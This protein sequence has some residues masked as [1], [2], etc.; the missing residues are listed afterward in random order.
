MEKV[1]KKEVTF[2]TSDSD[3]YVIETI[4][5][6]ISDEKMEEIKKSMQICKD[7][8]FIENVR[9]CFDNFDFFDSEENDVTD[10]WRV[11]VSQLIVYKDGIYFYAQNKYDASDQLESEEILLSDLEN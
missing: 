5:L 4:Q 8:Q 6:T 10:V 1:I 11:D 3:N 2:R 9:I 7:N